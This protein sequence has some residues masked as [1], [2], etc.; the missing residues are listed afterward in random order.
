MNGAS[1]TNNCPAWDFKQSAM[2]QL[3]SDILCLSETFL[4]AD[5]GITI[6][7]YV[8]FGQNRTILNSKANRGSGGVGILIHHRILKRFTVSIL[9]Q[10]Y[11]G[12]FWVQLE[13]IETGRLLL[14][15]VCYL[16]P[17]DSTKSVDGLAFFDKLL[18]D[19]YKFQN[20]GQIVIGG[21]FNARCGSRSDY[22]E[23]VDK[24]PSRNVIDEYENCYGDYILNFLVDVN[25]CMLNGRIGSNNYTSISHR[26]KAVVDYIIVPHTQMVDHTA[27]EVIKVT[28]L[29]S[30]LGLPLPA[31]LTQ[32]PDHSLLRTTINLGFEVDR[33]SNQ[34]TQQHHD[35]K[36]KVDQLPGDFMSHTHDYI[37]EAINQI[38]DDIMARDDINKAYS[39]LCTMV[40][41]EMDRCL[42]KKCT[43]VHR[44][45]R[46]VKPTKLKCKP[47]WDNELTTRWELVSESEK[48][49]LCHRGP[50]KSRA[51]PGKSRA[52][53]IFSLAKR[54][55]DYAHRRARRKYQKQ[56]QKDLATAHQ[57]SGTDFWRKLKSLGIGKEQTQQIPLVTKDEDG[58]LSA[59]VGRCLDKWEHI[60]KS[61]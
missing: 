55:F 60:Y 54:N 11:E 34:T 42:A 50:G 39:T 18:C 41:N 12:I 29:A 19:I 9:E 47:W 33:P 45:S 4:R 49:W 56:Q 21:D 24:I 57:I 5:N 23:G 8:W 2:Q 14:V 22:I 6:P 59:D 26:G 46:A 20:L 44:T 58:N 25:F 31:N 43:K 38:S 13:S 27:F 1:Y 3:D 52:K 10:D 16:P 37:Q 36:Y 48:L 61:L 30:D 35:V 28:D 32:L 51:K 15:C 17:K 7:N 53:S 40:S